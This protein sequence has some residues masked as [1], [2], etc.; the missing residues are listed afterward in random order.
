MSWVLQ[1]GGEFEHIMHNGYILCIV[2]LLLSNLML[3]VIWALKNMQLQ[4]YNRVNRML[5]L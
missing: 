1:E 3:T 2:R 5:L 4:H